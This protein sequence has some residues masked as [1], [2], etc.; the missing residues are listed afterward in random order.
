MLHAFIMDMI[1]FIITVF[2][3]PRI[4]LTK[5]CLVFQLAINVQAQPA[6]R[7]VPAQEPGTPTVTNTQRAASRT[8]IRQ[9]RL[10]LRVR[11]LFVLLFCN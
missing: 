2:T 5:T 11:V 3:H 9:L 4:M 1:I 8:L 6:S 10:Q 7:L